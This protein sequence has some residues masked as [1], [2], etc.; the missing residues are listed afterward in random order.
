[1]G[2]PYEVLRGGH[3]RQR[4]QHDEN[5]RFKEP[6][7][8]EW[9]RETDGQTDRQRMRDSDGRR[10]QVTQG[11]TGLVFTLR[12]SGSNWQLWLRRVRLR[13][14]WGPP[15]PSSAL[16]DLGPSALLPAP[17]PPSCAGGSERPK[18]P[19]QGMAGSVHPESPCREWCPQGGDPCS[20]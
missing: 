5:L 15:K 18:A 2:Q 4:E 12:A 3:V 8:A 20:L 19:P 13:D 1:M 14:S 6:K 10:R 11:L 7:E 16:R 17:P 9:A